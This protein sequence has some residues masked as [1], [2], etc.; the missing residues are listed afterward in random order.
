MALSLHITTY[1][2]YVDRL[3]KP[4]SCIESYDQFMMFKENSRNIC[5]RSNSYSISS[6]SSSK[7]DKS[8]SSKKELKKGFTFDEI[9]TNILLHYK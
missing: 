2:T 5:S 8:P 4:S 3:L 9:S 1:E 6:N 7:S